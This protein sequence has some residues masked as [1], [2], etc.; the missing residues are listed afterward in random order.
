MLLSSM[1]WIATN[2]AVPTHGVMRKSN[3]IGAGW[4]FCPTARGKNIVPKIVVLLIIST[5]ILMILNNP[6]KIIIV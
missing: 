4:N 2:K 1:E 6:N 5:M 3:A